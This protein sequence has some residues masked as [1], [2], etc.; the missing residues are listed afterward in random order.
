MNLKRISI[1]AICLVGATIF[2]ALAF[3]VVLKQGQTNSR[4]V[5]ISFPEKPVQVVEVV[6]GDTIRVSVADIASTEASRN[7][8]IKTIKNFYN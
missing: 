7:E 6:E 8:D 2:A 3:I 5:A 1:L 4:S